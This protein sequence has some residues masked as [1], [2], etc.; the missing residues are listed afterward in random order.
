MEANV[1]IYYKLE[2]GY[3]I[4]STAAIK[5]LGL[6]GALPDYTILSAGASHFRL[7]MDANIIGTWP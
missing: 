6:W 5:N 7:D 3:L 1:S 2:F 4:I